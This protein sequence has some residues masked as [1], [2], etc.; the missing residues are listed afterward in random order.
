MQNDAIFP[1]KVLSHSS[2]QQ[3]MEKTRNSWKPCIAIENLKKVPESW[4]FW[5]FF[6]IYKIPLVSISKDHEKCCCICCLGAHTDRHSYIWKK[7]RHF[8]WPVWVLISGISQI[9]K[10][11]DS[12]TFLDLQNSTCKYPYRPWEGPPFLPPRHSHRDPHSYGRKKLRNFAC[13]FMVLKVEFSKSEK[14]CQNSEILRILALFWI[15]KIPHAS[16]LTSHVKCCGFF[17]IQVLCRAVLNPGTQRG[18]GEG[19]GCGRQFILA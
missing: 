3:R 13:H 5:H 4:G 8:T 16:T 10:I 12:G 2:A 18:K 15:C 7:L 17:S 19:W 14:K 11:Q 9:W 6:Q 1:T